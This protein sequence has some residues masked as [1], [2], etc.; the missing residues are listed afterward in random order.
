[1]LLRISHLLVSGSSFD[2]KGQCLLS[3]WEQ[4]NAAL[5]RMMLAEKKGRKKE[6]RSSRIA[7]VRGVT[8]IPPCARGWVSS[9]SV[10]SLP[11]SF[12]IAGPRSQI[13]S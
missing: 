3:V 12:Q 11:S 5:V 6:E 7:E 2:E 9:T 13:R 10:A 8:T 4:R 1:M